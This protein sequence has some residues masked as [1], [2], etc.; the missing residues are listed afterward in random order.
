VIICV[1]AALSG[2]PCPGTLKVTL[3]K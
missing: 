2:K 1:Q 3:P